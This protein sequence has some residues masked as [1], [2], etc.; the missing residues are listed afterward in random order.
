MAGV[1]SVNVANSY[2][3]Q[4][5]QAIQKTSKVLSAG[6]NYPS[7]SY[8]SAAYSIGQRMGSYIGATIQSVQN[9]QNASAM[10]KIAA[11][12]TGNTIDALTSIQQYL[13]NAANGVNSDSDRAAIQQNIN[14]IIQQIDDN[15]L[16]NYNGTN[17]LDGSRDGVMVAGVS[18]YENIALGNM[19]SQALGLTDEQGNSTIDVSNDEA[20]QNSLKAVGGALEYVKGVNDSLQATL[21]GGDVLG[22]SLDE[23]TDQGAYLQRLEYQINNYNTMAE[24]TQAAETTLTAADIAQQMTALQSEEVQQR[25]ALE[26]SK[27]HNHDQEA[28]IEMLQ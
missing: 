4:S 23:A 24:N 11:G 14:Q 21:Q 5:T 7:S 18:G 26:M 20:I 27:L 13:V 19:T 2:L 1:G 9:T 8:G 16:A 28:A 17:L 25:F 12:A 6:S 3:N 15:A 10:I 22:Y